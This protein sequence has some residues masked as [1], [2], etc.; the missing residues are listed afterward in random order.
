MQRS[1]STYPLSKFINASPKSLLIIHEPQLSGQ[2]RCPNP[3]DEIDVCRRCSLDE[4][5]NLHTNESIG[6]KPFGKL[7]TTHLRES[8]EAA[9][10]DAFTEKMEQ[11][12]EDETAFF[13]R[14]RELGRGAGL[15]AGGNLVYARDDD[16]A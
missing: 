9:W 15:D 10:L 5:A 7:D 12:S 4:G 1:F 13:A 3:E 6:D 2:C 11:P 8:E 16:A 14:R